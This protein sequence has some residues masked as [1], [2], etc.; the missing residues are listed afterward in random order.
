M[1]W[2]PRILSFYIFLTGTRLNNLI[3]DNVIGLKI[4]K[5]KCAS[6]SKFVEIIWKPLSL[7][8]YHIRS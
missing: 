2:L 3:L 1:G 6:G 5:W 7:N 8:E 4:L